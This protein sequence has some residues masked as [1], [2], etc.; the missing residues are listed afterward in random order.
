MKIAIACLAGSMLSIGPVTAV[1]GTPEQ[2]EFTT[3][4]PIDECQFSTTGRNRYFSIEPGDEWLLEGQDDEG[5]MV[6]VQ[7]RVLH[8]T[9]WIDFRTPER[10]SLWVRTRVI[11]EREWKDD[12]LV[13][14]S[15]NFYAR[16]RP[17]NDIYYFGETVDIYEDGRIVS[18]DGAWRAGFDD[19]QPGLIMPGSFLLGSRYH[20]EIAPRVALDRAE[21]V[22]MGFEV[23]VLAGDFEECVRVTETTPL[24]PDSESTKIYCAE[25]GPVADNE[26]ELVEYEIEDEEDD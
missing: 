6:R 16:C 20:Q 3:E 4:F 7:I 25:I 15:R 21:H 9:Q 23:D 14:V 19:A 5:A 13:E 24:E 22:D 12:E 26:A 10:E 8:R 1:A 18:H 2:A 17:T 11:E